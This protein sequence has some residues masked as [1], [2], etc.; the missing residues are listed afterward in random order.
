LKLLLRFN[1]TLLKKLAEN[2]IRKLQEIPFA[3]PPKSIASTARWTTQNHNQQFV[4]KGRCSAE[5][6]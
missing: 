5:C 2:E 6:D 1:Y 4:D 3:A